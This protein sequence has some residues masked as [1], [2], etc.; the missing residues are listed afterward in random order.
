MAILFEICAANFKPASGGS[1]ASRGNAL[2][3]GKSK[4]RFP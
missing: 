2:P 3:C 4:R 1:R